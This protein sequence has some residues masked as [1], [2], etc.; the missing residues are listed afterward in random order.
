MKDLVEQLRGQGTQKGAGADAGAGAGIA[1]NGPK[2]GSVTAATGDGASAAVPGAGAA[3]TPSSSPAYQAPP[4]DLDHVV[5]AVEHGCF[6][7]S[8]KIHNC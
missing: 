8:N 3:A 6:V 4:F 2:A 5:G 7:T 1:S